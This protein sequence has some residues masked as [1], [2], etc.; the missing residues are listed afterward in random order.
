[1]KYNPI[2]KV[3]R[4]VIKKGLHLLDDSIARIRGEFQHA[5]LSLFHEFV[6]PPTGGG[7]QFMR[8]FQNGSQLHGFSVENNTISRSTKACLFNAFN[9][10]ADRLRRLRRPSV[11]YVH[12]VDGPVGIIRGRDEGIDNNI[13]LMNREFADKTIFQSQYSYQKHLELGFDLRNPTIITNAANPLIFHREGHIPFSRDRK[14]RLIA[15][16]WSDNQNKGASVYKWMDENLDWNLYEFTF[17]GNSPVQFNN[18]RKIA[19]VPSNKLVEYLHNNDV[20][21]TASK[22]DPCSNS[23]IE[24]LSCG[25]PAIYLKSGGHPEIVGEAGLGFDSEEEIPHILEKITEE[26]QMFQSRINNPT[27]DEVVEQYLKVLELI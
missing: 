21:I 2:P 4:P 27:L 6:P 1:M 7:H 24:A 11:V 5:D 12:R 19:A 15:T 10:D 3:F 22:N 14:I 8:A 18:I 16:S 23:L 25:L 17:V 9:F 26:Y 13:F 20:Y